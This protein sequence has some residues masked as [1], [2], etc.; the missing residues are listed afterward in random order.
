MARGRGRGQAQTALAARETGAGRGDAEQALTGARRRGATPASMDARAKERAAKEQR[1][2]ARVIKARSLISE[3]VQSLAQAPEFQAYLRTVGRFHHYSP[4]NQMLIRMQAP[5]ASRVASE[6]TWRKLGR[7]RIQGERP[8]HILTPRFRSL[9]IEDEDSGEETTIRVVD[10]TRFGTGSVYDVRQTEGDPLPEPPQPVPLTSDSPAA[11]ELVR[12]VGAY[13]SANGIDYAAVAGR[14]SGVLVRGE[15]GRPRIE[16]SPDLARD[17]RALVFAREAARAALADDE[18]AQALSGP[19]RE[20]AC[21]GASYAIAAGMGIDAEQATFPALA[22]IASDPVRMRA[23]MRAITT[24]TH[25]VLR[26]EDPDGGRAVAA[27]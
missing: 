10:P 24:A 22:R 15:D 18:G 25:T 5:D 13:C 20:L 16:I 11:E 6:S 21:V 3:G 7:R 1:I 14:Q 26:V 27:D 9:R 19:E 17:Q 12:R 4:F 8:I 2:R 23:V